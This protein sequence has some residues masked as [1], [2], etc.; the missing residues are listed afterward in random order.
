MKLKM[1][2]LNELP[3]NNIGYI[4]NINCERQYKKK[5]IR[6]RTSKRS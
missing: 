5:T 4:E 3:L 1:I 6:L 2:N